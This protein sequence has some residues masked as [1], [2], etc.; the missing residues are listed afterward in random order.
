MRIL[1][2]TP[3]LQHPPASGPALRIENS[4]KALSRVSELHIASRVN[5]SQLGGAAGEHFYRRFCRS[6]S[7]APSTL[8]YWPDRVLTWLVQKSDR[9]F[10]GGV[11]AKL[12]CL[13]ENAET[14]LDARFLLKQIERYDIEILWFGYGNISFPLIQ[15][16]RLARPDLKLVCDTDSVWSR[17]ILRE[18]P[19]TDEPERRA[20]IGQRGLAKEAEERAWVELCDVTTAVSAVDADYYRSIC[21]Q[22]EKIH[23]FSNVIDLSTY[24]TAPPAPDNFHQPC[25]YL[26]GSFGHYYSPMD[27]A[28][29]WVLEEIL[30][31]IRK[32][33]PEVHFYILGSGSD[34]TMSYANSP[35]V[36]VTGRL[37][38]VLPYLCHADVAIVPL[39]FESGTR[40]KILEAAVCSV[41][42]VSTTLGAEG[43]PVQNGVH[44]LV[45]DEAETF[46]AAVVEM[47]RNRRAAREMAQN[48]KE[49]VERSFSVEHLQ[50]EALSVLEFL[51]H[52]SR[53]A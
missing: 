19:F 34:R 48:C 51:T 38:S 53:L 28:A 8:L 20:E 39:K 13:T 41:P 52:G 5:G 44:M 25:V 23:L 24:R 47:I 22:P 40:F 18:L 4:I 43:L 11:L 35:S 33:I 6:F 29:R 27:Q 50:S 7:Y 12:A 1:F 42:I 9:S 46:A 32:D 26:A 36:T 49:L 30:P 14:L 37:P 21:S 31:L 45:A 2:T 15:A 10:F 16:I 3:V 17:F